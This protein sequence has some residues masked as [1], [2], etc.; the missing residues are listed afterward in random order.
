MNHKIG[1]SAM[2]VLADAKTVEELDF[3]FAVMNKSY[4]VLRGQIEIMELLGDG[5]LV[6]DSEDR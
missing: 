5:P 1:F 2:Q 4:A 6:V 3:A